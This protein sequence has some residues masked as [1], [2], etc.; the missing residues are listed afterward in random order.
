MKSL[1][2]EDIVES[3][4]LEAHPEGGYYREFYRAE[5]VVPESAL[6]SRYTGDRCMQTGIYYLLR[7]EDVS[8][9]HRIQS[10]ELIHFY[11]GDPVNVAMLLPDGTAFIKRI[12][13]RITSGDRPVVEIP[14][15]VWFGMYLDDDADYG[16]LGTTVSPGFEFDDFELGDCEELTRKYPQKKDLIRRL[17]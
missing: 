5:D 10:D 14:Q 3:L 6:P 8:L 11:T 2:A 12:S 4:E 7:S 17:T 1:T 15:G 13:D 16:L 9:L